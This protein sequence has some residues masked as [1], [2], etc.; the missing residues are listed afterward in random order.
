MD[1]ESDHCRSPLAWML[2]H[3]IPGAYWLSE[4]NYGNGMYT[5]G[6]PDGFAMP[7]GLPIE[8]KADRGSLYTGNSKYPA[9]KSKDWKPGDLLPQT[10]GLHTSQRNW[11]GQMCRQPG[12]YIPYYMAA[13]INPITKG[14]IKHEFDRL[15]LVNVDVWLD[16]EYIATTRYDTHSI[17]LNATTTNYKY[18]RELNV[19]RWFGAYALDQYQRVN[20]K[21]KKT[22]AWRIPATHPVWDDLR[23]HQLTILTNIEF[24]TTEGKP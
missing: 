10:T 20:E 22:F 13:W 17:P 18:R 3:T 2:N 21:G 9:S 6:K 8:C 4:A 19:E 14:N 11:L 23:Q 1:L 15:F 12:A 7:W 24:I 16:M 5:S